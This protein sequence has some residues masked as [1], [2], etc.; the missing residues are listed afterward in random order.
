MGEARMQFDHSKLA[1]RIKEKFRT[2]ARLAKALNWP[3]SK[4]SNRMNNKI[5]LSD[6]EIW[7][8]CA[9]DCLDIAPEEITLYFFTPKF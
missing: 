7:T 2:Q 3:P 6:D 8:L 5:P 9:P 4:L 1:G